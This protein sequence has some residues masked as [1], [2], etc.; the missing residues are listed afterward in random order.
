MTKSVEITQLIIETLTT[1]GDWSQHPWWESDINFLQQSGITITDVKAA[2]GALF[3]AF[4]PA[5]AKKKMH[6]EPEH[7]F[8]HSICIP[9]RPMLEALTELGLSLSI[10]ESAAPDLAAKLRTKL[11]EQ[12]DR[13]GAVFEVIVAA[14][15]ARS[16]RTLRGDPQGRAG[17]ILDLLVP[18]SPELHVEDKII[19]AEEAEER[20]LML[21]Q[22]VWD[23]LRPQL[24][25]ACGEARNVR[26]DLSEYVVYLLLAP[27]Q[28]SRLDV[29]SLREH[30]RGIADGLIR[31]LKMHDR[32]GYGSDE[33]VGVQCES[34]PREHEGVQVTLYGP[35]VESKGVAFRIYRNALLDAVE[36]FVD[37][38]NGVVFV[39][40]RRLPVDLS[41]L[42]R[43]W[44]IAITTTDVFRNVAAIV[45]NWHS[46]SKEARFDE[47]L[48]VI[49]T[50]H[51]HPHCEDV[52][53]LLRRLLSAASTVVLDTP[54]P[55]DSA[56]ARLT[57]I[58]VSMTVPGGATKSV[59][60]QHLDPPL[61]LVEK[62]LRAR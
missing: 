51:R 32:N 16:Y 52:S 54:A 58:N 10:I 38:A 59:V 39:E 8:L 2:F 5:W 20:G 43:L 53:A 27:T 15:F 45:I 30:A 35:T 18:S 57:S 29:G 14:I 9:Y 22:A 62:F 34:W 23:A 24:A 55:G 49:F 11:R 36:K 6:E 44:Q 50:N 61:D 31:V 13:G 47:R 56:P 37:G 40:L 25:D 4:D 41:Y 46:P 21:L 19:G 7:W 60:I 12:N 42:S 3:R 28:R 17:K 48:A 26:I 33:F 1:S